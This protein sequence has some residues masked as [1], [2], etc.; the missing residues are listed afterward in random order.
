MNKNRTR[1]VT[2]ASALDQ[3]RTV[4]A[5]WAEGRL[6]N[7][8][9]RQKELALLHANIKSSSTSLIKAICDGERFYHILCGWH[10]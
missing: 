6:E 4:S 3:Y 1:A 7:V 5:A 2:M 10:W 8:L 9:Q